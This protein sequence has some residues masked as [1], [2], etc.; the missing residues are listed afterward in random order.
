MRTKKCSKKCM[1]IKRT[2]CQVTSPRWRHRPFLTLLPFTGRTTNICSRA[3]QHWENSRTQ[4]WI[5]APPD[6][7]RPPRLDS[8]LT[9]LPLPRTAQHTQKIPLSLQFP[10]TEKRTQGENCLPQ[11]CGE[12]YGSPSSDL[13]PQG[14]QRNLQGQIWLSWRSGVCL[15]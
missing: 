1:G 7:Q 15:Q 9:E 10:Q 4:G 11:H 5:Q 8:T 3:R 13:P 12:L 6:P 2:T 14:L